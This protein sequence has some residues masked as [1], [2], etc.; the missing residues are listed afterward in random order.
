MTSEPARPRTVLR[1]ASAALGLAWS[2]A[3]GLL[4]AQ[5]ALTVV[6]GV[7][8]VVTAVLGKQA[9]DRL[10]GP[11]AALAPLLWLAAG[12]GAAGLVASVVPQAMRYI[13]SETERRVGVRAQE[14][15]YIAVNRQ[16]GLTRLED[17]RFQDRLQMAEQASR[18]GPGQLVSSALGLVQALIG[19]AGFT[20]ALVAVSPLTAATVLVAALPML[21][22]HL[23]LNR[24]Q[25]AMLWRTGHA[26]RRHM[27][28][29]RLLTTPGVAQEVRLFGLGDFFRDRMRTELTAVNDE[30]RRLGRRQLR[31][32]TL[33]GTVSAVVAGGGLMWMIAETVAG[34]ATLGDVSMFIAAM[35]GVQSSLAGGVQH[36]AAAHQALLL[37]E[38]FRAVVADE[39]DL[40]VPA[41]PRP[42]PALRHGIELRDVW[43][44]YNAEHP[45]ILRGVDLFIPH[46]QTVALVGL[47]G[48]GKSTL[49]KLLCRFY[50][51]TRGSI[52]WDG[53]DLREMDP[54]GLRER[55]GA[56]FQ[57]FTAYDLSAAENVA[58][59]DLSALHDRP[60]VEEA[61][62]RA[63]VHETLGALPRGYDTLLSRFFLQGSPTD[64]PQVGVVLS[65]GQWQRLALARALLRSR[66][67]LVILDEPSA[68]LDAQAEYEVHAALRR[69]RTGLT[70]LLIS[71]RLSAVREADRIVVLGDGRP[72]E[73]GSHAEL[74]ALGRRYAELFDVQARGYADAGVPR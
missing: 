65:G 44:R 6:G 21:R 7:L 34:R 56:I 23:S 62:G 55:I 29:A 22:V 47:N 61:A 2:A 33:L 46:G 24:E 63:G 25:A 26:Q 66:R 59:G 70:T 18:S 50:D 14:R 48:A 11:G 4:A 68:G 36:A 30:Y 31:G 27:F 41:H 52:H 15:L 39:P 28:F 38:H 74:M 72:V 42:A 71:H 8:P 5:V 40:P 3:P 45:W 9:F 69:H 53:V 19:V 35:A 49:V 73:D 10:A 1:H 13:T 12:M 51:P 16:P 57:D 64:D 20:A 58:V 67:D 54:A 43:F 17:P 37:F 32:H 60:R